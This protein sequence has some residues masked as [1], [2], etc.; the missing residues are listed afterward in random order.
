VGGGSSDVAVTFLLLFDSDIFPHAA[1]NFA[2][3][4]ISKKSWR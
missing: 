4:P 2:N 3:K 1:G